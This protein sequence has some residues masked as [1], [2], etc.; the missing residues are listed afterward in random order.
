MIRLMTS[1]IRNGTWEGVFN[2]SGAP[3]PSIRVTLDG[4]SLSEVTVVSEEGSCT[5]RVDIPAALLSD[6]VQTFLVQDTTR[7]ATIAHFAIV[8]GVSFDSDLRAEVDLLRAELDM[9]K[10]AFRRHCLETD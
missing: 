9:L 10:S 1:T 8:T 6:G 2:T 4:Q 3:A 7:G 5:V